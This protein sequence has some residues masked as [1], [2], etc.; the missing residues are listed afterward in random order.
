MRPLG[1]RAGL[2]Q[3]ANSPRGKWKSHMSLSTLNCGHFTRTVPAGVRDDVSDESRVCCRFM[4]INQGTLRHSLRF[5][6][7]YEACIFF[8]ASDVTRCQ[9]TTSCSHSS[10]ITLK[11]ADRHFINKL[12]LNQVKR[13][14]EKQQQLVKTNLDPCF[15]ARDDAILFFKW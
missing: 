3:K 7:I 15:S 6:N 5:M 8:L 2:F 12:I 4:E 1:F 13:F 10:C 9:K 14:G 11:L